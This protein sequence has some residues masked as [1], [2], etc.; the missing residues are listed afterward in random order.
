MTRYE[1]LHE[2]LDRHTPLCWT[3]PALVSA[4]VRR[5][6]QRTVHQAVKIPVEQLGIDNAVIL[7]ITAEIATQATA[8]AEGGP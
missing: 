4:A 7:E 2:Q 8:T 3:G 5:R 1:I 6:L